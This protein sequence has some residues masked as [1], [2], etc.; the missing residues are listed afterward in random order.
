MDTTTGISPS[1]V[2]ALALRILGGCRGVVYRQYPHLDAALAGLVP[3]CAK[4]TEIV[5]TDGLRLFFSGQK[6]LADYA[7]CPQRMHR[8]YLHLLLH[9]L[10]LHVIG[11]KQYEPRRWDLACDIAVERMVRQI[12]KDQAEFCSPSEEKVRQVHQA[13]WQNN[14][15]R[16]KLPFLVGVPILHN[17]H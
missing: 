13:G 8:R 7:A 15:K 3:E 5:G 17:H 1:S 6:V 4:E 12:C 11:A 14:F 16:M 2:E 10:Y 9:G